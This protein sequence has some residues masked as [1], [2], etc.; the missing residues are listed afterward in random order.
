MQPPATV[1]M[2]GT[3]TTPL[4][5]GR[6][7]GSDPRVSSQDE[8]EEG[9]GA[10]RTRRLLRSSQARTRWA[11][12]R[13]FLATLG[14]AMAMTAGFISATQ[15]IER[16]RQTSQEQQQQL[17]GGVGGGGGAGEGAGG[18]A[19]EQSA[20]GNELASTAHESSELPS[21]LR[22]GVPSSSGGVAGGGWRSNSI[23]KNPGRPFYTLCLRGS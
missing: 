3:E 21:A 18:G 9:V 14:F 12:D 4:I 17:Q 1:N 7:P 15:T 19:E 22:L 13:V 23:S 8:E 6:A 10:G 5:R 16:F 2:K 11:P 20:S